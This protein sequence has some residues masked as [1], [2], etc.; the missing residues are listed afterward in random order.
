MYDVGLRES[1]LKMVIK[2]FSS[3]VVRANF[4]PKLLKL[5]N[6]FNLAESVGEKT[7]KKTFKVFIEV[8]I[9]PA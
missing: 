2:P 4:S 7:K 8:N 3:T 9:P 1:L 6:F 5:Y